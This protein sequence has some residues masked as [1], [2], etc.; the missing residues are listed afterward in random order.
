MCITKI[1]LQNLCYNTKEAAAVQ[2]AGSTFEKK[3]T[4]SLQIYFVSFKWML[5]NKEWVDL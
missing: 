4:N 1:Q 5:L 2:H 3:P